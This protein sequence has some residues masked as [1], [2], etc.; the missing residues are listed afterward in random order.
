MTDLP[1]PTIVRTDGQTFVGLA[2]DFDMARRAE[3][4]AL[5]ARFFAA[6]DKIE[7]ARPGAIYVLSFDAR[8]DGR[9]RYAVA[10]EVDLPGAMPEGFSVLQA[11][12]GAYADFRQ[13]TPIGDLPRRFDAVF[14][15]WLP[16]SGYA[17]RDGAVFER[18]PDDDAPEAGRMLY[19][20]WLP[21]APG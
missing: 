17:L 7:G 13:R 20:I 11:G 1:E 15:H 4:P 14:G 16:A 10:I 2:D 5:Y 18:Y 8:P 3:I 21:V 9:F 12:A 19:E 6:R